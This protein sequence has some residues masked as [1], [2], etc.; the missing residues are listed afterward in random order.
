VTL[1]LPTEVPPFELLDVD[2]D[3]ERPSGEA[4]LV[5]RSTGTLVRADAQLPLTVEG[6]FDGTSE[7]GELAVS[8]RDLAPSLFGNLVAEAGAAEASQLGYDAELDAMRL[9]LSGTLR[10]ALAERRLRRVAVDLTGGA[11]RIDVPGGVE[12]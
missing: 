6:R 9:P 2:L 7:V 5:L 12:L 10:F 8:F 11:G 3:L 1:V 4:R